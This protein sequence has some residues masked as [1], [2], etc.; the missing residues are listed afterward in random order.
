[1]LVGFLA[2]FSAC[3]KKELNFTLKGK[4]N[5]STFNKA[6]EG[7]KISIFKLSL[8]STSP[9]EAID[10][11]VIGSAGT[12][13]F[14]F[15]REKAEAYLVR[16][17]KENY[18][19]IE[20][21][22]PFSSFSTEKALEKNFSTTAKAWV[23]I[24]FVNQAPALTTDILKYI[25]MNGKSNCIECCPTS[26]QFLNGIIDSTI[27][28]VNDGNTNYSFYHWIMNTPTQE[29]HTIYTPAF[30]TVTYTLAY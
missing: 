27:T 6:L 20:E 12:F 9:T 4:I 8:G 16:I 25:K 14:T 10:E 19:L 13:E 26:E 17:E 28:C 15:P 21:S 7:A 18:F 1:M 5:D 22:I 30:D 29:Q 23:K 2:V 24:R 3:K 11:M